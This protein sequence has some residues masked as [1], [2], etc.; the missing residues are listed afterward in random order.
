MVAETAEASPY[1]LTLHLP[2]ESRLKFG[3]EDEDETRRRVE[4]D[5]SD[6]DEPPATPLF[7]GSFG[8]SFDLDAFREQLSCD[9][10]VGKGKSTATWNFEVV[11]HV[12]IVSDDFCHPKLTEP[13]PG[14]EQARRVKP[15]RPVPHIFAKDFVKGL[16]FDDGRWIF[17]GQINDWPGMQDLMLV[18][19]TKAT[20]ALGMKTIDR[21]WN[22][23]GRPTAAALGTGCR[24]TFLAPRWT[25]FGWSPDSPGFVFWFSEYH[26]GRPRLLHGQ[27]ML[28]VLR[29][30][31]PITRNSNL[32][33]ITLYAHRYPAAQETIRDRQTYHAFL[34]AEWDHHEFVT[35]IELGFRHATGA[36]SGKSN[37]QEDKLE[38]QRKLSQQMEAVCPWM[39]RPWDG[40]TSEIRI[41]DMMKRSREEFE[42]FLRHYG[43]KTDPE[44]KLLFGSKSPLPL[45]QMRFVDCEK[46]NSGKLKLR[47]CNPEMLAGFLLN[48]V[49]RVWGY[50]LLQLNCQTFAADLFAFLTGDRNVKPFSPLCGP[51]YQQHVMSFVYE[52]R[53]EE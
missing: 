18:S 24:A 47:M 25:A 8:E 21:V 28:D 39:I 32:E 23:V 3:E 29:N 13:A 16:I 49:K 36:G 42:D 17:K 48:Y 10:P 31:D 41:V 20:K 30:D 1:V 15:R 44:N 53:E 11:W 35:V 34:L 51:A 19:I 37:W 7:S 5:S 27:Q 46:R 12:K 6:D 45:D 4:A 22:G 52:P 9:G 33:Q 50:R 14:D 26:G 40:T 38:P 2:P 43:N